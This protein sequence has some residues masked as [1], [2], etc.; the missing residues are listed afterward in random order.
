MVKYD[1]MGEFNLNS[2]ISARLKTKELYLIVLAYI[3]DL[4][5]F[6]M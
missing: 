2:K 6:F 1:L 5:Y 4:V 3:S